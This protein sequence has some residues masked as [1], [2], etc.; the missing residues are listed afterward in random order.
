MCEHAVTQIKELYLQVKWP[1]FA[2]LA[3]SSWSRCSLGMCIKRAVHFPETTTVA[4]LGFRIKSHSVSRHGI[5][6]TSKEARES[7]DF[8]WDSMRW[9]KVPVRIPFPK[10]KAK[11][12]HQKMSSMTRGIPLWTGRRWASVCPQVFIHEAQGHTLRSGWKW[13]SIKA[14]PAPCHAS[15]R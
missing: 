3:L 9:D 10:G 15:L 5:E 11:P 14:E 12:A 2:A 8:I 13:Q 7:D 4:W 1:S 6:L